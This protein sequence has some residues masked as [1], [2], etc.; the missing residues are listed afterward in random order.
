MKTYNPPAKY[1]SI[2]E[3]LAHE[4]QEPL[5]GKALSALANFKVSSSIALALVLFFAVSVGS[6]T[7]VAYTEMT[8]SGLAYENSVVSNSVGQPENGRVLGMASYGYNQPSCNRGNCLNHTL[9]GFQNGGWQAQI[10]YQLQPGV[11]G[12][13]K[14]NGWPFLNNISGHGSGLTGHD[15]EPGDNYNFILYQKVGR[16]L[17]RLT[18]LSLT[19]PEKPHRNSVC[20]ARPLSKGCHLDYSTDDEC[21]VEVCELQPVCSY[22]APPLDCTYV[23]GGFYNPETNCGLELRCNNSTPSYG[24]MGHLTFKESSTVPIS[25]PVPAGSSNVTL[26]NIDIKSEIVMDVASFSHQIDSLVFE[27]DPARA[28][29]N[30]PTVFLYHGSTVLAKA[31]YR[32]QIQCFTSPCPAHHE[33]VFKLTQPLYIPMGQTVSLSVRGDVSN[34]ANGSISIRPTTYSIVSGTTYPTGSGGL[35]SWWSQRVVFG[36]P[37]P[38]LKVLSP[39]GGEKVNK[40]EIYNIKWESNISESGYVVIALYKGNACMSKPGGSFNLC[41]IDVNM[42]VGEHTSIRVPN[43]GSY[44]WKVSTQIPD[45]NDY[46]IAVG[47]HEVGNPSPGLHWLLVDSSNA[48]FSI[49]NPPQ[50][51]YKLKIITPTNGSTIYQNFYEP[52]RWESSNISRVNLYAEAQFMLPCPLNTNCSQVLPNYEIAKFLYNPGI[53]DWKV[54]TYYGNGTMPPGKY[55]L[56][57]EGYNATGQLVA[58]DVIDFKIESKIFT[59]PPLDVSISNMRVSDSVLVKGQTYRFKWDSSGI[60]KM[61]IWLFKKSSGTQVVH[62]ISD[63]AKNNNYIDWTVPT[64]LPD[65]NDYY[66]RVTGKSSGDLGSSETAVFSIQSGIIAC[67]PPP[68]ITCRQNQTTIWREEN[69]CRVSEGCVDLQPNVS[70]NTTNANTNTSI[71]TS[72]YP[73]YRQ[74]KIETPT[75]NSWVAWRE[76]EVF[77]HLG[78]KVAI[79]SA[80]VTSEYKDS[81]ASRAY[82]GNVNTVWNS[83]SQNNSSIILDLGSD[84]QVSMIRLLPASFPNPAT[85]SHYVRAKSSGDTSFKYLN[86]FGVL[87]KDNEWLEYKLE[88]R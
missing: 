54:G 23:P 72:N 46:Y 49:M 16:K 4:A 12:V 43:T 71:V 56:R 61:Y 13:V 21:G 40:G 53:N 73:S 8:N 7:L 47:S 44:E 39:N 31:Q 76:I 66:A 62:W 27:A 83:G 26:A 58:N 25:N 37:P 48:P 77:D 1:A 11:V 15:L 33:L 55:K 9:T 52:I 24:Y 29:E 86:S 69:G 63:V 10:D 84:K 14:V 28:L 80:S 60:E 6:I 65:G 78:K 64:N 32:G 75:S 30:V 59:Q 34:S 36:P 70:N 85:A 87:I 35:R 88:R 38:L 79:S 50:D 57:I 45:G 68:Q 41:G 20:P 81:V 74:I 5:W 67:V 2:S 3:M 18:S 42:R 17:R 51:N 22:P 19:A 82:D